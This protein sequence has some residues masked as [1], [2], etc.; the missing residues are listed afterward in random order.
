MRWTPPMTVAVAA[1]AALSVA[2]GPLAGCVSDEPVVISRDA[3]G[4]VVSVT[5]YGEDETAVREAVDAA[6][7][8]MAEVE[9]ALDAYDSASDLSRFNAD[10]YTEQALP[11]DAIEV[12]DSVDELGVGDE[13]SPA[14]LGVVGLYDFEGTPSVPETS[15]LAIAV[16]AADGFIRVGEDRATFSRSMG[17]DPRL[18]P[19]G[20][21][22]PGLD[23][24]GAAK[25]LA[26]DRAREALRSSG[27]VTAALISAVS[28]T[29][30]LGT[31][32]DG[33]TWRIGVEDPRDSTTVVAVFQLTGEGAVSTSGDYQRYF[34]QD[35]VRYH[36]ILHPESGTP[37]RG[38]RSVT[39]GGA[40]LSGLE[41]DILSTAL[42]VKGPGN[43]SAYAEAAGLGLYVVD[44]EGRAL[45]VPA[46]DDSGLIVAELDS[47]TP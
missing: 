21:L 27:S 36:H 13:F 2:L 14:L 19:G 16:S 47:P 12:L 5:A 43:A 41:S 22:A 32:P 1:L 29:V 45:T 40:D 4:T 17:P 8:A 30:T 42:F 3:L 6:F 15:D 38:V 23:F 11:A 35:G 46:P 25:G 10:P 39:V 26:L 33:A 44:D 18:E 31:K 24:G 28:T 37:V 20:A 34:E 9:A 7:A